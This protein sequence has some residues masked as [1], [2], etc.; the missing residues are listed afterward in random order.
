ME[1][2][3]DRRQNGD[4]LFWYV[5]QDRDFFDDLGSTGSRDFRQVLEGLV[6]E[7]WRMQTT[8]IWLHVYPSR[9]NLPVQG[10]KIHVSATSVTAPEV[11]RRVVPVCIANGTAFKIMADP[12]ILEFATCKNYW[13]GGSG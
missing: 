10:F 11:L 2:T 4:S 3:I 1:P 12:R 13:S 7:G 8:G 6:P 5:V 9:V